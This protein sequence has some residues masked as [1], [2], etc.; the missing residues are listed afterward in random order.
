[1]K[2]TNR[3]KY[4]IDVIMSVCLLFVMA[5]QVT[6][7]KYHE[8]FGVGMLLLFLVHNI[9]N[10]K[11]YQCLLKGKYNFRRIVWT[12][13]NLAA[14]GAVLITGYSGMA[15]SRY[16]FSSLDISTGVLAVRSLHLA[17]SYWTFVL[18]SCHLGIHWG[19][20]VGILLEKTNR[21]KLLLW[22]FRAAAF[23]FASY[24]AVCVYHHDIY[25]YMFLKNQFA[26]M[27]YE[28]AAVFVLLEHAAMMGTFVYVVYYLMRVLKVLTSKKKDLY[29][30]HV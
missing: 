23:A 28:K 30:A 7:D 22:G 8:W 11:W 24:G 26:F 29:K 9:L 2:K 17:G 3:I 10:L 4:I 27:D 19:M 5:Y 25:S 14:L 16:V 21:N 20:I 15:M 13:T 12:V 6:G 18:M 1:M